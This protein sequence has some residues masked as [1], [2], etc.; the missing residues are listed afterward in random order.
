[1]AKTYFIVDDHEMLRVGITGWL[2]DNSDFTCLEDAGTLQD[3]L[4][5]LDKYAKAGTL[6]SILISDI[7]FSGENAGFDLIRLVHEK[8][9][10]I[11][12]I[13]YSMF[14][15]P[16]VMKEAFINGASGYI[17]KNAKT[18]ELLN[19]MNTV[20]AG[21]SYIEKGLVQNHVNYNSIIDSLTKREADVARFLVQRRSNDEIAELLGLKKR[22]VENYISSIYEKL[23]VFD[24]NALI[25]KLS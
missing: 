19:C 3:A 8:Y 11:K 6:P 17:S 10:A 1:M 18:E 13:V 25:A 16:N 7:N 5:S 4:E 20:M 9:P 21:D 15:S 2:K 12:I 24:R 14:F 23:G 22:S